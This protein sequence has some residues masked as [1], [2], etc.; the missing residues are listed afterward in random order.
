MS[1]NV[2]EK[3]DEPRLMHRLPSV[4]VVAASRASTKNPRERRAIDVPRRLGST[5][6]HCV[7]AYARESARG[8]RL[9]A[10]AAA[11][12]RAS[13]GRPDVRAMTVLLAQAKELCD[14]RRRGLVRGLVDC[15]RGGEAIARR[16]RAFAETNAW[17]ATELECA[18]GDAAA[19]GAMKRALAKAEREE[20]MM[21]EE[22]LGSSRKRGR[23]ST[24]VEETKAKA[25]ATMADDGR[26]P[27]ISAPSPVFA[28]DQEKDEDDD[29]D[30]EDEANDKSED[31][32]MLTAEEPEESSDE[33]TLTPSPT[34]ETQPLSGDDSEPELDTFTSPTTKN[35]VQILMEMDARNAAYSLDP[36]TE[37]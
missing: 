5:A 30:D 19:I 10:A 33:E 29:G 9:A 13:R 27:R 32:L 4:A 25:G 15:A 17:T 14:R 7:E 31:Q 35:V 11:C 8:R 16:L 3:C 2:E 36:E 28:A 34:V 23:A 1:T 6:D 18:G 24:D 22:T 20:A 26:S 21:V 12:A 37:E